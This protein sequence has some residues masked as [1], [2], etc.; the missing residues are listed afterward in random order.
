MAPP[1]DYFDEEIAIGYDAEH[2]DRGDL[3]QTVARL[4]QLAGDGTAL[5]LAIGT[6]RVALPLRAA[7]VDVSGIELSKPMVAQMRQKPGGKDI[8]VVIGDMA[9]TKAD[10]AFSL[11]FLV[12]NTI[13]NLTT[14]EQQTRC[15]LNAA[16]HL[17]PGG[18]FVIETLV[19]PIQRLPAGETKLAFDV[20]ATHWGIDEYDIATQSFISHHLWARGEKTVRRSIPFRYVWPAELD[21]MA[22]LAGMALESRWEDWET[23]PFTATS[24][25]HISVWRK[26]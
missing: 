26:N 7:G 13:C 21:L 20:S 3:D 17:E 8:R 2:T 23:T 5:E 1:P 25:R 22:R 11:V 19:P 16:D 12:F 15:F 14:Q 9:S 10:G 4:A 24:T 18:R 6:G